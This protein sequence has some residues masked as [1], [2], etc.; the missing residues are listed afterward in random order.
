MTFASGE[1]PRPDWLRTHPRAWLAAVATVCFSAFMGQLDASVVALTYHAIG[2]DFGAPLGMVQWV[3]LSYLAALG[4]LLI[5]AG[6]LSDRLGR[7]RVYLWGFGAFTA[8]SAGCAL[9]PSLPVLVAVRAVQGAGA[10]MLQANSVALVTTTAPRHRLRLALG[11]QAAAQAVGLAVGPTLG[12]LIVGTVGWRWVFAANV[13]IGV[14]A[15]VAG[16]FLLPRTRIDTGD[17]AGTIRSVLAVPHVRPGLAGALLGYLVLF[18]PIV[19]VPALLQGHGAGA[20]RSGLVVA[21]L[22]I[23]FALAATMGGRLLTHTRVTRSRGTAGLAVA[24]AGLAGLLAAGHAQL[25]IAVALAVL[26]VG[27]GLFIPA[28]TALVMG[29]VPHSAAAL[30]GGLVNTAR[31]AGTALGTALVAV[32]LTLDANGRASVIGLLAVAA[33]AIAVSARSRR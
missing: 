15:V 3:T 23:G 17:T 26:G 16:R 30:A 11:I 9:A 20:L 32:T 28:N 24:V 31:T 33:L 4:A 6:R 13:P 27:L 1:R 7:K 5:P 8:A 29:E 2:H 14:L 18:G 25:P 10:A 19:L 12:G 21:A 22:P